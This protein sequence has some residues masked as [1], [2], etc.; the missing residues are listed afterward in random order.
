[1]RAAKAKATSGRARIGT[2]ATA[3]AATVELDEDDVDTAV[4]PAVDGVYNDDMPPPRDPG[5]D[6]AASGRVDGIPAARSTPVRPG[7][8]QQPRRSGGP[9]R[10]RPTGKKKRR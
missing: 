6:L 5:G 3:T 4:D 2:G 1:M 9:A 7:P 8:R 10:H